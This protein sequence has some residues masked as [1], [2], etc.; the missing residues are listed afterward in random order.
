MTI[1]DITI[2]WKIFV[3]IIGVLFIPFIVYNI[4]KDFNS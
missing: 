1:Y 4:F 2:F 3:T